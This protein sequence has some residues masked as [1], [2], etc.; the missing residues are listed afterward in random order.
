MIVFYNGKISRSLLTIYIYIDT[1]IHIASAD[2]YTNDN[3]QTPFG[4]RQ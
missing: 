3:Y 1:K 2:K 4:G